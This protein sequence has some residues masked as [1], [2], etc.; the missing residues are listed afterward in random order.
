[1]LK[2]KKRNRKEKKKKKKLEPAPW[3]QTT[4]ACPHHLH[5]A[6]RSVSSA[7]SRSYATDRWALRTGQSLGTWISCASGG[8]AWVAR[9]FSLPAWRR[10]RN[11]G[12]FGFTRIPPLKVA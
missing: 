4:L 8:W 11:I 3:A 12:S 5:Q 9:L 1:M 7:S 10:T 2:L 6:A